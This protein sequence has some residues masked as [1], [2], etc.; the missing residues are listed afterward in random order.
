VVGYHRIRL[1]QSP[2]DE[3]PEDLIVTEGPVAE[4]HH[5]E[6]GD[7]KVAEGRTIQLVVKHGRLSI[8][9]GE[10]QSLYYVGDRKVYERYWEQERDRHA[11][12]EGDKDHVE[13]AW[14]LEMQSILWSTVEVDILL[15]C[16]W[17]RPIL[18]APTAPI[19]KPEERPDAKG[20]GEFNDWKHRGSEH[21]RNQRGSNVVIPLLGQ[22][23]VQTCVKKRDPLQ[24]CILKVC[25]RKKEQDGCVEELRYE[26]ARHDGPRL[27]AISVVADESDQDNIDSLQHHI[28]CYDGEGHQQTD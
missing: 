2:L 12:S 5:E 15:D 21:R 22:V 11:I 26:D 19:Q 13:H 10:C 17:L 4:E 20:Y 28:D 23:W 8:G 18:I 14:I 1:L 25:I 16:F 7:F 3:V 9:V 6:W 27:L 24:D